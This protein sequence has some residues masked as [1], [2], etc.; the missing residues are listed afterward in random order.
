M[1]AW[2]YAQVISVFMLVS[3][4]F[5]PIGVASLFASRDVCLHKNK[6]F[7]FFFLKVPVIY[8]V[9]KEIFGWQVVEIVDRY[10]TE[11]IP[12]SHRGDKVKYIQSSENKACNRTLK[13]GS[14]FSL[15]MVPRWHLK[16]PMFL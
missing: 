3:I 10:E 14:L 12:E 7:P 4:I 8:V 2:V 15:L 1:S 5:V 16:V 13:V 9:Y 6:L 11:C